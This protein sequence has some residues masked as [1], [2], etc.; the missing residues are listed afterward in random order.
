MSGRN[1]HGLNDIKDIFKRLALKCE[2]KDLNTA[3]RD[4]FVCGLSDYY[5]KVELFKKS[6]L[7]FGDAYKEPI[8]RESA[9]K[10]ANAALKNPRPPERSRDDVLAFKSV[11][12]RNWRQQNSSSAENCKSHKDKIKNRKAAKT[13]VL[14]AG[15]NA[16]NQ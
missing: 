3:L 14:A 12:M 2:F 11:N 6:K 10:N 7:T 5:T 4:Q 16:F 15:K 8:S 1:M 13:E 9:E